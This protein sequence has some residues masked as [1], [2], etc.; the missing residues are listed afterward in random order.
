MGSDVNFGLAGGPG[1]FGARAFRHCVKLQVVRFLSPPP[2]TYLRSTP[3]HTNTIVAA[4]VCP[5]I[6]QVHARGRD[7]SPTRQMASNRTIPAREPPNDGGMGRMLYAMPT[8]SL[9]SS[10]VLP[11]T[12]EQITWL[13]GRAA[14]GRRAAH[15]QSCVP[16]RTTRAEGVWPRR[17]LPRPAPE[18]RLIHSHGDDS[19]TPGF[20][21]C[22]CLQHANNPKQ[23]AGQH[24]QVFSAP[25]PRAQPK[26]RDATPSCAPSMVNVVGQ[27][28]SF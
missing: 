5:N 1:D 4:V 6:F 19:R 26:D 13:A 14:V 7:F 10:S 25:L 23:A 27:R 9:A 15:C 24:A 8:F 3:P 12:F 18:S 20:N 2:S 22:K 16:H 28:S 11:G 21:L 17:P